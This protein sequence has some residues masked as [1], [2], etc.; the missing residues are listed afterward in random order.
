MRAGARD[1]QRRDVASRS[2]GALASIPGRSYAAG[3]AA[4]PRS[5]E[6]AAGAVHANDGCVVQSQGQ[7]ELR[8]RRVR[9]LLPRT[10]R[11]DDPGSARGLRLRQGSAR[12]YLLPPGSKKRNMAEV[13]VLD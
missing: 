9:S 10:S 4:R 13:R 1:L 3:Y 5:L 7:L 2:I 11:A 8:R 12:E 6:P